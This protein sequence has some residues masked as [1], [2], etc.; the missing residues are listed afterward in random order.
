MKRKQTTSFIPPKQR[1]LVAVQAHFRKAGQHDS[2]DAV[3]DDDAAIEEGLQELSE[4]RSEQLAAT[5]EETESTLFCHPE[6]EAKPGESPV[7]QCS[8]AC[9]QTQPRKCVTPANSAVCN[10]S[11]SVIGGTTTIK[12]K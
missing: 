5:T 11:K 2:D 8:Y 6:S 12:K 9:D 7:V 4:L 1:N 10:Q 3:W